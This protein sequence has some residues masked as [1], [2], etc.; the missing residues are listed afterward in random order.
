M[1]Y[2]TEGSGFV[3][4]PCALTAPMRT[5]YLGDKEKN[6]SEILWETDFF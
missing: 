2:G 5:Q 1:E 3:P 6:G 4:L